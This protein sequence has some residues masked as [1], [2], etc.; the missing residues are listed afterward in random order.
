MN[1]HIRQKAKEDLEQI[2]LYSFD[3]WG[4]EQADAYFYSLNEGMQKI[5]DNPHIG[6]SCDYIRLGYRHFQIKKHLIFYKIENN[7]IHIIR[8]LYETMDYKNIVD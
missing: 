1:I 5:G 2:W 7:L 4:E 8:I 3:K 6:V